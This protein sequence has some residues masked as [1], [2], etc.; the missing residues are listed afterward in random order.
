MRLGSFARFASL[1]PI[2]LL[3]GSCSPV[4]EP[5]G[6]ALFLVA[7]VDTAVGATTQTSLAV[8]GT[9]GLH[10]AY[11][12]EDPSTLRY[13]TCA[14]T[15]AEDASWAHTT[16]DTTSNSGFSN[17]IVVGAGGLHVVYQVYNG[18][19]DIRY[20]TC[21]ATCL[22]TSS[23]QTV[24]ID[25]AGNTGHDAALAIEPAGQLH[26][27]Y[28]ESVPVAGG[29]WR[30]KY[31]TCSATC[32]NPASWTSVV[33]D[34]AVFLDASTRALAVDANG[35]LHLAY[36][37]SDTVASVK[38]IV[39]STCASSC[40][41]T[42]NWQFAQ[43]EEDPRDHA[44]PVVALDV[45]GVPSVA[46]WGKAGPSATIVYA[47]CNGVCT[48]TIGWDVLPIQVIDASTSDLDQHSLVIDAAGRPQM[49]F[50]HGGLAYAGC[51]SSCTVPGAWLEFLIDPGVAGPGSSVAGLP[52]GGV[53]IV[54]LSPANGRLKVAISN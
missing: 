38:P 42:A 35:R 49:S 32:T 20:A 41:N 27:T 5:P 24:T 10:A 7:T 47:R 8:D 45:L 52:G 1:V 31:A 34:S 11:S 22:Q 16:I 17:S 39:Y 29:L 26:V 28:L 43:I 44:A 46:Y 15:C 18:Q 23:W 54:Y 12:Q 50:Q 21:A 25:S 2:T 6:S 9:G 4:S 53:G 40:T 33:L 51:I 48:T 36:Q 30:L 13:A 37:K 14:T 19:G 3:L